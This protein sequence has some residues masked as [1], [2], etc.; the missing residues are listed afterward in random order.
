MADEMKKIEEEIRKLG[1]QFEA[2]TNKW[3]K[4]VDSESDKVVRFVKGN[5]K[6]FSDTISR[7]RRKIELRSEIGERTRTLTKAY[8]RLGEAYYDS[9]KNGR[10]MDSMKDVIALIDSNR[11]LVELLQEKLDG[12]E[13]ADQTESEN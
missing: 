9:M 2:Q 4:Y 13:K 5:T 1:E 12:L 3:L 8:T 10:N 11:K 6:D 7:E